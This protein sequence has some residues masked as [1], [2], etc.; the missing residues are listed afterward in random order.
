MTAAPAA[1][2]G[3]A[4]P[5]AA[6]VAAATLAGLHDLTPARLRALCLEFGGPVGALR[7]VHRGSGAAFLLARAR[8]DGR[9]ALAR[10]SSS[11][12]AHADPARVE[13]QLVARATR[14]WLDED[15][16][17]PIADEVPGRPLV[18]LAEGEPVDV[19]DR[20]RVAIVGTRA[21]TPHGLADAH[22]LGAYLAEAGVTVVSGL[23]IGIDAAAHEGALEAGGGVVG[24]VATGLDIE[25]PR[26]HVSLYRRVRAAGL[27]LGETGFGVRPSPKRFPVRNRIIAAL[28]DVV[29]VV[30]ATRR[31]G[32]RITAEHGAH[33]GRAVFAVPGSRRNASA[34]GTNA[35]L[36]DG[37]QVLLE[38]S[39]VI[40]AL[41]LTP[42]SR[43]AAP[44]RATPSVT[45]QAVLRALGGEPAS[46][47]QLA[48][49]GR[50][51]AEDVAMAIA[52]LERAGW[53]HRERGWIWPR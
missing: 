22:E 19:L 35:L 8:P 24:V 4:R 11:W 36:A 17:Y 5:G 12:R 51:A 40:V 1:T 31:G 33:Y 6:H 48:T 3:P 37:A 15:A 32:A 14:V 53:V 38:W 50:L 16:S 47:D 21:A 30:E 7:A 44:V 9:P 52:E 49:R 2:G 42:G 20:P 46:P 39:D 23:A 45:G 13:A 29:V 26:R 28:A 18:L 34:E 41:G 27:V 43:R 25:Y 10:A